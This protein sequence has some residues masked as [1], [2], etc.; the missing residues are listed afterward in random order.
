MLLAV[1]PPCLHWYREREILDHLPPHTVSYDYEDDAES[2]WATIPRWLWT[3][4]LP[5]RGYVEE[6]RFKDDSEMREANVKA[7]AGLSELR[8]LRFPIRLADQ[9]MS[10]LIFLTC[11]GSSF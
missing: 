3:P 9:P 1:F 10:L 8:R 7:L 6:V 5:W 11:R 4:A 2:G